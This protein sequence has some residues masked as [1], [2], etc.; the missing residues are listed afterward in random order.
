MSHKTLVI[1][2]PLLLSVVPFAHAHNVSL[3]EADALYQA[4]AYAQAAEGY[5]RIVETTADP[6][7]R[8]RGLL[9]LGDCAY[10]GGPVDDEWADAFYAQVLDQGYSPYL[11]EAYRKWRAATQALW[12]GV[13][14]FSD[15]PTEEYQTR[16]QRVLEVI[17]AYLRTVPDD[18]TALA[19]QDALRQLPDLQRGGP[20]G[21]SVLNE[22]GLLWPEVLPK[23]THTKHR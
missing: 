5:R 14:N 4:G 16:K 21:S 15:I 1:A 8:L 12:H 10:L 22:M 3:T 2:L 23:V 17:A 7:T 19:Q 11:A 6:D 18:P 20:M 13:S 9:R